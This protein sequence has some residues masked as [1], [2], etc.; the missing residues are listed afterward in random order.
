MRTPPTASAERLAQVAWRLP[1]ATVKS[2]HQQSRR[3]R[4]PSARAVGQRRVSSPRSR[5]NAHDA[6]VEGSVTDGRNPA[7][8][9]NEQ[10]R[11]RRRL[12]VH[13]LDRPPSKAC[14]LRADAVTALQAAEDI[15]AARPA[16][17]LGA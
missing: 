14:H 3:W 10:R 17:A 15:N 6:A 9:T 8:S 1:R 7:C 2:T 16:T 13:Q 5:P 4:C 11:I 12:Q